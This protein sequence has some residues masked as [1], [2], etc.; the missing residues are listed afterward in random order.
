MAE[1]TV[2]V[3]ID[4]NKLDPNAGAIVLALKLL[5]P[6][7]L[8]EI[9]KAIATSHEVQDANQLLQE[10]AKRFIE[11]NRGV[12]EFLAFFQKREL[13]T[14]ATNLGRFTDDL[15]SLKGFGSEF[16]SYLD[17]FKKSFQELFVGEKETPLAPKPGPIRFPPLFDGRDAVDGHAGGGLVPVDGSASE[18]GTLVARFDGGA[19]S[20]DR[21]GETM[22]CFREVSRDTME[23][24]DRVATAAFGHLEQ[25]LVDFAETGKFEWRG[26]ARVALDAIDD[27]FA[28]QM[29]AVG[30][31]SSGGG[32]LFGAF[33]DILSGVFGSL[34]GPPREHGG[35]VAPGR[36]FLV[37]EAGPEL[38]VPPAIGEIVPAHALGAA[39]PP[40]VIINQHFDFKGAS[41]YF[42]PWTGA[43]SRPPGSEPPGEGRGA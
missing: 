14:S 34:F 31:D 13:R 1:T 6:E 12:K 11:L 23:E 10:E 20:V 32:G 26:L 22:G 38:F 33:G 2:T 39:A 42:S 30:A 19:E 21:L 28:A 36:A 35:P 17:K 29:K 24:L 40:T 18:I 4:I 25:V 8:S 5:A 3:P 7:G 41:P 9:K 37:G 16:Q 15:E 43:S 27:I